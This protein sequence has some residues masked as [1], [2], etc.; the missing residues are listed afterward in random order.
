[1]KYLVCLL[2]AVTFMACESDSSSF[3]LEGSASGFEDGTSVYV[4]KVGGDNRPEIA[5]T[6]TINQGTFKG[7]FPKTEEI[8]VNYLTIDGAQ[9]NVIYFP[10]NENL[11]ATIY[12][13][14]IAASFVSGSKQNDAYAT[15]SKKMKEFNEQKASNV[16]RFNQ[17]RREQ[18]NMLVSQIQQENIA[19]VAEETSYK[20]NFIIENGNSLFSAMLL[21]EMVNRKEVNAQL[22]N[23]YIKSFSPKVAATKVTEELK[24]TLASLKKADIGAEAPN[25]TAPTPDGEM[26]SLTDALG[27][28]TII[29]FWA[30]WCRPCRIEN[31][32]VVRVYEK[33]HDKGLNIISVSLDKSGQKE[34]WIK[35]I[36]DDNMNWYHVSNLKF[37]QDPIARQ[38]NVRSI[39]AT[40]L[41]DENGNI[42]DKN[43]RGAALEN[44]IASL[45]GG[46]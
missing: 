2:A 44:K 36:E 29:D 27:K 7:S 30:S 23:T 13:D 42:I 37:W 15:F 22:A 24:T 38:Y 40:F 9:A 19:L 26:L 5:D 46:Q 1:M 35:A 45:M 6:L 43:L 34:R 8:S 41:L 39:P 18:D 12:K 3:T 28:Y 14:S 20:K 11:K 4:Y 25:F 31:P 10:E 16:Q 17:A 21:S 33:Y 32:N